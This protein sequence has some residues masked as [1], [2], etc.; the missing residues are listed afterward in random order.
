MMGQINLPWDLKRSGKRF[1][2]YC[3]FI[4]NRIRDSVQVRFRDED[5]VSERAIVT[6]NTDHLSAGAMV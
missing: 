6:Q 2:E 5:L 4:L 1:G 3:G